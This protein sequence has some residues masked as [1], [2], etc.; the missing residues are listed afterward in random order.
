MTSQALTRRERRN[1]VLVRNATHFFAECAYSILVA[2]DRANVASSKS[3]SRP[4]A[5]MF[6]DF[7]FRSEL[8]SVVGVAEP[9]VGLLHPSL[10][11]LHL[12]SSRL[13]RIRRVRRI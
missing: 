1:R 7:L 12:N 11:L 2:T 13:H 8:H 9:L 6:A 5:C 3:P 10:H 4:S